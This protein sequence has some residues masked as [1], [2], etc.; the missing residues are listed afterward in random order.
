M[1]RLP[2]DDRPGSKLQPSGA[3]RRRETGRSRWLRPSWLL[4][5]HGLLILTVL[6]IAFFSVVLADTFPT[7]ATMRA[8]F[9]S[10]STTAMLALGETIVVAAGQFDLSIGYLLDICAVLAIGL[11]VRGHLG[12]VPTALLIVLF[13]TFVGLVNGL[14]VQVAKIESFIATLGIGTVCYGIAEWYTGGQQIAGAL[15]GAFLALSQS[16]PF[17]IPLPA[18]YVLAAAILLWVCLE[19]LPIGRYLYATGSNRRAA[20]LVGVPV[21]RYTI[22]AFMASGFLAALAAV[23]LASQLGVGQSTVGEEYLLPA[24]VGALLGATTIRPGRVNAWGTI[25]AVLILAVGIAGLEQLG[26][27][28]FVD[29]LFQGGTLVVAVG[30][31]GYVARRRRRAARAS[32]DTEAARNSSSVTSEGGGKQPQ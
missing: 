13:G 19:F 20:E 3:R 5:T 29:P 25:V 1:S 4:E 30:V 12:W 18:L 24:F 26:A 28:F 27:A 7:Q 22:G 6:L 15:P 2:V 31:A 16:G 23:V 8:I 14:L 32:K 10:S 17:G 9:Q 11:Q 21:G